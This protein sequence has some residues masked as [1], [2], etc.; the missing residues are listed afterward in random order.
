V[1][2]DN[3][4][5][6]EAR[7]KERKDKEEKAKRGFFGFGT[8]KKTTVDEEEDHEDYE[9][10]HT[11][12]MTAKRLEAQRRETEQL[13]YSMSAAGIFFKRTDVDT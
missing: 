8:S 12:Q 5:E 4:A 13:F 11:L 3:R 1:H 2:F 6:K 9:E 10:V 7:L